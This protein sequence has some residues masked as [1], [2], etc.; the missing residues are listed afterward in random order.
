MNGDG[1]KTPAVGAVDFGCL[2]RVT[3]ISRVFGFDRGLCIDRYYIEGF[4]KAH[5]TAIRGRVLEIGDASYTIKFGGDRVLHSDVLHINPDEPG[6]TLHDDLGDPDCSIPENT[7]DCIILTQTLIVIPNFHQAI[8]TLYRILS[9]GGV[10][11]ATFPGLAQI[12]R[13]DMERW[14]EFWRFTDLSAHRLFSKVFGP[15]AISVDTHGNVLAAVSYLHGL[16][17]EELS[18]EELD[19]QDPDYQVVITVRAV[20]ESL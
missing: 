2:R 8:S 14:G 7:F 6:A 5:R 16:A 4:L 19:H 10:V 20:K 11:L 3:P 1:H 18:P 17:S 13:Y 12:S 9:P 15:E